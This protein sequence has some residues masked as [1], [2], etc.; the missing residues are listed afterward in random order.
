MELEM[1]KDGGKGWDAKT[2][3]M[4]PG[5][6]GAEDRHWDPAGLE[7]GIGQ[8][9]GPIWHPWGSLLLVRVTAPQPHPQSLS[10]GN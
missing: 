9:G 3:R 2:G 10:C 8:P 1:Q 6:K 7:V 5:R 4:Q